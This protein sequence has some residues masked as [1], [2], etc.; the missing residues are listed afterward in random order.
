MRVKIS[1]KLSDGNARGKYGDVTFTMLASNIYAVRLD[2][3]RTVTVP[4]NMTE[5]VDQ[6]EAIWEIL[7]ELFDDIFDDARFKN[8]VGTEALTKIKRSQ[9]LRDIRYDYINELVKMVKGE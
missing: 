4:I 9:K 7:N 5:P 1:E 3:G 8:V 6:R 2:D